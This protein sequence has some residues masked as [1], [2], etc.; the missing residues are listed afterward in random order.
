MQ[1]GAVLRSELAKLFGL[2]FSLLERLIY[3]DLYARN[4][5]KFADHGSYDP[6]LVKKKELAPYSK[7]RFLPLNSKFKYREIFFGIN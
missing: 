4:E 5:Q 3:S 1:L 6:L 7:K 2:D